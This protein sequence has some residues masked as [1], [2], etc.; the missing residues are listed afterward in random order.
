MISIWLS[1]CDSDLEFYQQVIYALSKRFDTPVFEPH[2]TL[3][4]D[5]SRQWCDEN[6][7]YFIDI[8]KH[9]LPIEL[10]MQPLESMY[11]Y[12]QCFY[13]RSLTG[14]FELIQ[15]H[16]LSMDIFKL[17]ETPFMPH[18]SLMY[19]DFDKAVIDS[20]IEEYGDCLDRK[21][22]FDKVKFVETGENVEDWRVLETL[23][24]GRQQNEKIYRP[25]IPSHMF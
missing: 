19:G 4:A 7:K 15:L 10:E 23:N 8:A 2:L 6:Y 24:I 9:R 16:L 14:H 18:M 22:T 12:F 20:L 1:P 17:Q 13:L 11:R 3:Q 21:V 25:F 5:I